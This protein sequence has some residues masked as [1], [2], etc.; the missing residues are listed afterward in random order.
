M[1]KYWNVVIACG[2]LYFLAVLIFAVFTLNDKED[3]DRE[4]LVLKLNEIAHKVE[5]ERPDTGSIN[6]AQY[7][8]DVVVTDTM[9][10]VL[11]STVPVENGRLSV[12]TAIK[13]G[14][15]YRYII[16]GGQTPGYVMIP[17]DGPGRT[18]QLRIRII[19]G[20]CVTGAALIIAAGVF[21]MYVTKHIY[22][23]FRELK[24]FAG[25]VAEGKLDE[26][27]SMDRGNMFGAFSESFDI[28]REELR[29]SRMREADLQKRE[30]EL[31]ASLS[32]DLKTP[33]TGIKVT[34]ELLM[35]KLDA[36]GGMDD[37]KEKIANIH[38][39]ADQIDVL[40]SDLFSVTLEGLGEFKVNC[41]D[42]SSL[43]LTDILNKYDD[44]GLVRSEDVPTVLIHIDLR[45]MNQVIGNI[46]SNSCKYAGTAIEVSYRIVE[47][48]L[49]MNIRDFG[50]GVPEDELGMILGKFYRGKKW[51]DSKEE[52]SGLGLYIA[53][54]L[55]EK[56][57]GQLVPSNE[58]KGFRITLM[59]PLS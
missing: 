41:T 46:I 27:L 39:K 13:K 34:C 55:M 47:E 3:T 42:E 2:T 24:D 52:G 49:E 56:M 33:I 14:Y 30:K 19:I 16:A 45:R 48:Y 58:E 20:L 21:G 35:A 7:G 5:E 9:G 18:G 44:K 53:S 8:V 36:L 51:V 29:S 17:D 11:F 10:E 4:A 26:P 15:P 54:T 37:H 40:V 32:H 6:H 25:R 31:V 50:P 12:E 28:M 38:K 23:P 59:I 22:R 1:K 57:D 43:V